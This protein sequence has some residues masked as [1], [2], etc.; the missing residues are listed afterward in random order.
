MTI[1]N[2]GEIFDL[3]KHI[4]DEYNEFYQKINKIIDHKDKLKDIIQSSTYKDFI[5]FPVYVVYLRDQFNKPLDEM[6][7]LLKT[8]QKKVS[9]QLE[10]AKQ[11]FKN[12]NAK[13]RYQIETK[14]I[15]LETIYKNITKH[16]EQ[17]KISIL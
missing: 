2:K 12:T 8:Y 15:N 16:L 4:E 9:T 14:I 7:Q 1:F 13:E 10:E 6:I 5:D 11:E 3:S 17:L